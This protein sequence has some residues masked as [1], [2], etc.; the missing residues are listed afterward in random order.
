MICADVLFLSIF[1]T[2]F[3]FVSSFEYS[4]ELSEKVHLNI[5]SDA[6]I[7][8]LSTSFPIFLAL[9]FFVEFSSSMQLIEC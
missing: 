7:I 8:G 1:H 5:Y 4:S 3:R 6:H 9:V 2:I